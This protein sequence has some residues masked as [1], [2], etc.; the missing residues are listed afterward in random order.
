MP[1]VSDVVALQRSRDKR[2]FLIRKASVIC[3]TQTFEEQGGRVPDEIDLA[4]TVG[5]L[6]A[7]RL[8]LLNL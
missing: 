3:C 4:L 2:R 7:D 1:A 6:E 8:A 5:Y